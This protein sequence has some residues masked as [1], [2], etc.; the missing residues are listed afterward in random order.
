MKKTVRYTLR[1]EDVPVEVTAW[2]PFVLWGY[3]FFAHKDIIKTGWAVT[4]TTTGLR[5]STAADRAGA[6]AQAK[7][8][9]RKYGKI[10]TKAAIQ[11]R[12]EP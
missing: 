12:A 8:R 6:I 5:V 11:R 3:T 10:A 1:G 7:K 4:E 9:L 2:M